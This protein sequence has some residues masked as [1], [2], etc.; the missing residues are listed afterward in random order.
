MLV[1]HRYLAVWNELADR[2][3]LAG[4]QQFWDHAAMTP[5]EPAKVGTSSVMKG[6]H[7]APRWPGCSKIIHYE[8]AGAGRIDYQYNAH[9]ADGARAMAPYSDHPV[10]SAA[11]YVDAV[12]AGGRRRVRGQDLSPPP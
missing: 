11:V 9:A 12:G 6:K 4:A 2:V 8:I 10:R 1:H 3:G 7:N 5:G